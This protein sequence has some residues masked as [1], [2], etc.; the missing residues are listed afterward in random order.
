VFAENG[1]EFPKDYPQ[2]NLAGQPAK[3]AVKV[4]QVQE[5]KLPELDDEFAKKLDIK[6]EKINNKSIK[7]KQIRNQICF[8]DLLPHKVL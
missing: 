1:I 7:I 4:L 6:E 5:A 8:F 2:Q 3:F